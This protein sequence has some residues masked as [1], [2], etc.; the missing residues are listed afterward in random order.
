MAYSYSRGT[1]RERT[2]ILVNH[3]WAFIYRTL[4][5]LKEAAAAAASSDVV[6][7]ASKVGNM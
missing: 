5:D 7:L 3:A 1:R 2:Y 4:G 6:L